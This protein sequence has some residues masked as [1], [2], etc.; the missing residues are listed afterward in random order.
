MNDKYDIDILCENC[1][2][3]TWLWIPNGMTTET[4]FGDKENQKCPRCG[5]FH[6]RKD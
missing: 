1:S 3:V 6:G 4:F 2:Q 5:C